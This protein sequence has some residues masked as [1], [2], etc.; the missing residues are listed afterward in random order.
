LT[1]RGLRLT[2]TQ[3]ICCRRWSGW[4][5]HKHRHTYTQQIMQPRPIN[6]FV[7]F[8]IVVKSVTRVLYE[9]LPYAVK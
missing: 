7:Y 3:L 6:H 1:A 5:A 9:Q 4:E 2:I 8:A